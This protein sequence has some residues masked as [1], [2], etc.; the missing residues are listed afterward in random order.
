MNGGQPFAW[1]CV[2]CS[3]AESKIRSENQTLLP[4]LNT[5]SD[6]LAEDVRSPSQIR[7]RLQS[8]IFLV[9]DMHCRL[10]R[11]RNG[12]RDRRRPTS[13]GDQP[14]GR[15][16]PQSIEREGAHTMSAA[17]AFDVA[18]NMNARWL[19]FPWTLDSP[20]AMKSP[21]YKRRSWNVRLPHL[22]GSCLNLRWPAS[23]S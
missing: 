20:W 18:T 12:C 19:T 21:S 2:T 6:R 14:P 17:E 22:V 13:G 15:T 9:V 1:S 7:L 16:Q 5:L 3:T 4:F 11:N 10:R 23:C 8:L